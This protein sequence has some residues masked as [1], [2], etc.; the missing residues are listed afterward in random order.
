MIKRKF[1]KGEYEYPA[2]QTKVVI[3]SIFTWIFFNENKGKSA[4][5]RSSM[6]TAACL[7]K[8]SIRNYVFTNTKIC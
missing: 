1:T 5:S 6:W 3:I 4:D 8:P 2:Y 7:Q